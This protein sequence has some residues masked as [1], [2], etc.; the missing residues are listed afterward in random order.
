MVSAGDIVMSLEAT[1]SPRAQR[2]QVEL[3][4]SRALKVASKSMV[5]LERVALE[6]ERL[7]KAIDAI[8]FPSPRCI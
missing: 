3:S 2:G 4:R 6:N 7:R 1:P 8:E 5:R